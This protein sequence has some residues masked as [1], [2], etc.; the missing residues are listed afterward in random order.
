M[1][2]LNNST[3]TVGMLVQVDKLYQPYQKDSEGGEGY[4]KAINADSTFTISW[5]NGRG[6]EHNVNPDRITCDSPLDVAARQ[7]NGDDLQRSSFL[8]PYH[9]S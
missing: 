6:V 1:R 2:I 8:S 4:V 5:I 7:K 3:L 9:V